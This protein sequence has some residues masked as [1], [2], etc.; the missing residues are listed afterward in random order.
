MELLENGEIMTMDE[1]NIRDASL[2]QSRLILIDIFNSHDENYSDD[3]KES[4][5]NEIGRLYDEACDSSY[6]L[7]RIGNK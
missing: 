4:L 6:M 7:A 3:F 5:N 1:V 2:T